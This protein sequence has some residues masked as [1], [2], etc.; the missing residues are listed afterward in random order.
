[1]KYSDF[2]DRV[3]DKVRIEDEWPASG[4]ATQE[5]VDLSYVA[6]LTVAAGLPLSAFQPADFDSSALTGAT[7]VLPA[8]DK[9]ALPSTVFRY[10]D[11]LGITSIFLDGVEYMLSEANP[12]DTLRNFAQNAIY[13]GAKMFTADLKD[14][15]LY[16][17][18]TQEVKLN[19]LKEPAKPDPGDVSS[20]DY[21]LDGTHA[22]QAA[23]IVASHVMGELKRD[24][25]GAQFQAILQKQYTN[26]SRRA[27]PAEAEPS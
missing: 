25:G 27:A 23:S 2:I 22:E 12:L 1:M 20:T 15:L 11:D 7:S 26:P 18:N 17:L 24:M 3:N 6:A 5:Q 16:V 14:R 8:L 9:Y 10:R 4:S 13:K 21:P 19:H